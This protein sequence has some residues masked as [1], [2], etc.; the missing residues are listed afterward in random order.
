MNIDQNESLRGVKELMTGMNETGSFLGQALVN[1]ESINANITKQTYNLRFENCT[2]ALELLS[3]PMTNSQ[4][5]QR[6][7]VH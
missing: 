4:T 7:Q 5:V 1:K 2:V 3:N 6:F